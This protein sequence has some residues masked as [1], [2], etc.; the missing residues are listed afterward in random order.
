MPHFKMLLKN[1]KT[2]KPQLGPFSVNKGLAAFS[3]DHW[4]CIAA[5]FGEL[6]AV[7]SCRRDLEAHKFG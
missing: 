2:I 1:P 7:P 3:V 6:N 4:M 5:C